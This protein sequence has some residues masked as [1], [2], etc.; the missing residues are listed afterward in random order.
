MGI[1]S[2]NQI[3]VF[4]AAETDIMSMR[5]VEQEVCRYWSVIFSTRGIAT[6]TKQD[7]TGFLK[8]ENNKRW[9]ELSKESVT[10]DMEKLKTALLHLTDEE[11]PLAIRLNNLE[12][13]HGELAVPHLGK[14]KLTAILL[15]TNVN[16]YGS[17][18]EYSER[19][20]R[21]MGLLAG[22][23]QETR[24]GDQY[25]VLNNVL[26]SLCQ[27]YSMNMWWLDIILEKIARTIN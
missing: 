3:A 11:V 23:A 24:L 2:Q 27:E 13:S 22:L 12:P 9:K 18:N 10:A 6:L 4:R 25:T 21:A 14:A 17:W 16:K 15:V 1:I 26:L 20:L 5:L 7:M 19:A 8:F